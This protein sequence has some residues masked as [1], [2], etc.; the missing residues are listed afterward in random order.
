MVSRCFAHV[1]QALFAVERH[2]EHTIVFDCGGEDQ[3]MVEKAV[4]HVLRDGEIIDILFISHYDRD[5][6]N[7]IKFLLK[8]HTVRHIVLPMIEDPI[9]AILIRQMHDSGDRKVELFIQDPQSW[10][11]YILNES[12]KFD[13]VYPEVHFVQPWAAEIAIRDRENDGEGYP[14]PTDIDEAGQVIPAG[15]ALT[16][17]RKTEWCK[18]HCAD[19]D[20]KC[21]CYWIY[22][23]F[24]RQVMTPDQ[25]QVFWYELGMLNN[26]TSDDVINQWEHIRRKI[27]SAWSTAT[28]LRKSDIND[29]SMTLYSGCRFPHHFNACLF[30]G[31]Y[32][33]R[34][35]MKELRFAYNILWDNIRVVQI[36]HHGS[37]NN[38]HKDLIIHYGIH[39]ISNRNQPN[40]NRQVNDTAVINKILSRG[41]YVAKTSYRNFC[42]PNN[43]YYWAD[44]CRLDYCGYCRYC[45]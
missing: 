27:K 12:D 4:N 36:P 18:C 20:P 42:T 8:N 28:G 15:V 37:W 17:N 29:Y 9:K 21:Q 11:T 1:G 38:F 6:I 5:H 26:S 25:L 31:D 23:P 30:T 33:A 35:R 32:N 40:N 34:S 24:N 44:R 2:C 14:E 10:L 16:I 7:G 19:E 22:L 43:D 39:V 13:S 41:E 3:K 45:R